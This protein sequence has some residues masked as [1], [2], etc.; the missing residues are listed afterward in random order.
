MGSGRQKMGGVKFLELL[1][2]KLE[3]L[4]LLEFKLRQIND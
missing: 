1:E 2:F 3:L 4:E